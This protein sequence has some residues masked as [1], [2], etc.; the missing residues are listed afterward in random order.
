MIN[1]PKPEQPKESNEELEKARIRELR[2]KRLGMSTS[3]ASSPPKEEKK[4]EEVDKKEQERMYYIL[5]LY[6]SESSKRTRTEI[7]NKRGSN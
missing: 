2:L 3:Q 6:H 1:D 7:K 5:V 4:K